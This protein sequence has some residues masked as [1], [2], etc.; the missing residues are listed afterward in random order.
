MKRRWFEIALFFAYIFFCVVLQQKYGW[1]WMLIL[2][3]A[4]VIS[5]CF[6]RWL[7]RYTHRKEFAEIERWKKERGK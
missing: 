2:A 4:Q 1:L 3:V 7:F 5:F 6:G